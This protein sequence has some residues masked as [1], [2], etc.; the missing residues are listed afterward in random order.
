MVRIVVETRLDMAH[1]TDGARCIDKIPL[2][3]GAIGENQQTGRE[4]SQRVLKRE[5]HDE[6]CDSQTG[7]QWSQ[8][9]ADVGQRD[10][11]PQQHDFVYY[12]IKCHIP[13]QN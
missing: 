1:L 8:L 7:E 3:V 6:S 13:E 9:H 10:E 2:V 12:I 4:V 11:E 5:T